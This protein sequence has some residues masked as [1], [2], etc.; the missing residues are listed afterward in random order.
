MQ[1]T[2]AIVICLTASVLARA[3]DELQYL[4][5]D[6]RRMTIRGTITE[7]T[8]TEVTIKSSTGAKE[9]KIPVFQILSIKYDGQPPELVNVG[10]KMKQGRYE[11]AIKDLTE[12]GKSGVDSE[13]LQLAL[14]YWIFEASAQIA[15]AD[16]AKFDD[17]MKWYE[18]LSKGAP[19]SRYHY[20][21]QELLGRMQLAKKDYPAAA[22]A[23]SE[24]GKVDWPGYRQRAEVYQ[25]IAALRQGDPTKAV[26][27]FDQVI[28][29]PASDSETVRQKLAAE[30]YKGEALVAAGKAADA[31][32]LLRQAL[33]KIPDD[34]DSYYDIKAVGHNALGDALQA[35]EQPKKVAMLDGYLWVVVVYNRDPD[36]L[37]RALYNCSQIFAQ[38]GSKDR[39][40][41]MAVR[42][43]TDFPNSVWTKK[44]DGAG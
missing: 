26:G 12:I 24:L 7:E 41:S 20:P 42:L 5:E 44:L 3:A 23:F 9:Q 10:T 11:D 43:R 2:L 36:Q 1:R 28:S 19:N 39:A 21:M 29:S 22:A 31:D 40:Q 37:A 4:R 13:Y 35:G 8:R 18:K 17:A 27:L 30:I 33:E 15:I 34:D 6:G 25:G 14:V 32:K 38:I 16:P